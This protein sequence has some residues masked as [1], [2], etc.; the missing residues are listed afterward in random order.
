[1]L[2]KFVYR[3]LHARI[4]NS[5]R[6]WRRRALFVQSMSD[7]DV[8]RALVREPPVRDAS[9][10]STMAQRALGRVGQEFGH[11]MTCSEARALSI[12]DLGRTH[13]S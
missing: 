13:M 10:D 4:V 2:P 1:M 8:R 11:D 7:A 6:V 5:Q 9:S 12:A 3:R